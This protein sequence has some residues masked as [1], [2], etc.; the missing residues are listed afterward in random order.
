MMEDDLPGAMDDRFLKSPYARAN[1]QGV[2]VHYLRARLLSGLAGVLFVVLL[3][4]HMAV[5][6]YAQFATIAGI[7]AT[8]GLLSSIG[9]EKAVT[10]YL[11]A[12]RIQQTSRVLARFIWRVLGLRI[13]LLIAATALLAGAWRLAGNLALAD[14]LLL[15]VAALVVAT[16]VFQFLA[17]ILQCLVQ[18]QTLSRVLI[19]Q[20]GGRLVL[21]AALLFFTPGISFRDAIIT[22]AIPEVLGSGVLLIALRRHLRHLIA[23]DMSLIVPK[24]HWPPWRE[25]RKLM[26]HNYGYAWLI[27]APQANALIV[28]VALLLSV[29]QVAAYGFFTSIVE[30]LRSYLPLQ[31][32]LNLAE[33]VLMASYVRDRDFAALCQRGNLLYQLNVVV[34]MLLLAWTSVVAPT[35]A[36]LLTGEKYAAFA[37]ILPLL[38]AQIALGSCNTILQVV[39]NCVGR[40]EILTRSGSV[41]LAAMAAS[42]LALMLSERTMILLLA[43][44]LVFEMANSAT[45]IH[46][47]RRAGFAYRWHGLFHLKVAAAGAAAWFV[48][49]QCVAGMTSALAQ[50]IVAGVLCASVFA[51]SCMLLRIVAPENVLA[52]KRLLRSRHQA[53]T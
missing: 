27:A 35:L 46:L 17:L 21:L 37:W 50:V 42:F 38:L 52:V 3:A 24:P 15:L 10:C 25:V 32:M 4:R 5:E 45:A 13:A 9:L 53:T 2:V 41:A 43:T 49:S 22:M 23:I 16:N 19:V 28:L 34:L 39:V 12:G 31:F 29:P 48:T 40:S 47:L 33:P 8:I 6:A 7:A 11:P 18:Q 26:Q 14:G 51:V 20:W 30:R 1:V 44:P 36:R